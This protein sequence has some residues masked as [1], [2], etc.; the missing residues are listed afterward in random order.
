MNLRA[1]AFALI[2]SMFVVGSALA[3]TY[4]STDGT[5]TLEARSIDV[6]SSKLVASGKAH[7]QWVDRTRKTSTTADAE[8]I[9]VVTMTSPA[10][11][12]AKGEKAQKPATTIKSAVLSGPVRIM[13]VSTTA[14]GKSTITATADSADFD[15]IA[16]VAHMVGNVRVVNDDPALFSVPATM[17]G[18]KATLNLKPGP[19]DFRFRIETAEPRIST[20]TA[21]PKAQKAE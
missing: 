19:E 2:I 6:M 18:D 17:S 1:A 11:P 4:K 21:T 3:V 9:V 7:I 20:I 15:G 13:Q 8:K 16:N 12:A 5:L 10:K 14:S